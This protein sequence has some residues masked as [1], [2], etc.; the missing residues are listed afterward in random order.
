MNKRN[1]NVINIRPKMGVFSV[2]AHLEYKPWFALAEYVDNSYQSYQENLDRIRRI[3]GP[4]AR[5]KVEITIDRPRKRIL[6][7][8]NA[9]GIAFGDFSRAFR[10]AEVPPN[11]GGL[12]EFGMGMKSASC[13]FSPVWSVRTSAIGDP[14]ERKVSF[15]VEKIVS[16]EIEDLEIKE[17]RVSAE[18]HYTVVELRKVRSLPATKTHTKIKTH[19]TDIY[20]HFLRDGEMELFFDGERLSFKEPAILVAPRYNNNGRPVDKNDIEWRKEVDIQIGLR[21][22]VHGFVALRKKLSNTLAGFSLFRRGRVIEGSG[23]N[24]YQPQEIMGAAGGFPAK[25]VFGELHLEG[26][27]VSHTKDGFRW[28]DDEEER[29]LS[30][31]KKAINSNPAPLLRQAKNYRESARED[32]PIKVIKKAIE[33]TTAVIEQ[34]GPNIVPSIKATPVSTDKPPESL[35]KSRASASETKEIVFTAD[36]EEWTISLEL[37]RDE[38]VQ[39]WLDISEKADPEKR[40]LGVRIGLASDF[41]TAMVDRTD[42]RE[43]ELITRIGA[44]LALSESLARAGGA[45]LVGE[46]RTNLNRILNEMKTSS[47]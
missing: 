38:S 3:E 32:T 11:R 13:W 28:A 5:L 39:D 18:A 2:L 16:E 9:G 12:S 41:V 26:F 10:P 25:R 7:K 1:E 45:K 47:K 14:V 15:D 6:I 44:G 23:E 19:L 35:T 21:R 30:E 20:R 17:K 29:F 4:D 33:S 40:T 34:H 43:V 22:R 37:S 8:D 24:K 27:E 46:V 36:Y 42:V 31:L